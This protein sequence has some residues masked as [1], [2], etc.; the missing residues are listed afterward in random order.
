[1]EYNK[2]DGYMLR[3]TTHEGENADT[4]ENNND[5]V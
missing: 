2:R 5:V 3:K 1:M 4:S